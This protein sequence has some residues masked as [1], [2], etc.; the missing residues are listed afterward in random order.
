MTMPEVTIVGSVNIDLI[1]WVERLP[2]PGTT[3]TGGTFER[4]GAA[5]S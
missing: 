1:L 3:V 2:G 5:P 4:I